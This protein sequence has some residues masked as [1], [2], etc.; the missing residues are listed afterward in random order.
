MLSG[1]L[2][3]PTDLCNKLWE[4][5]LQACGATSISRKKREPLLYFST[6]YRP[7][8]PYY[9]YRAGRLIHGADRSRVARLPSTY[10]FFKV[11][12]RREAFQ[13][14]ELALG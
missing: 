11:L 8:R 2:G 4:A 7:Y 10:F 3:T 9:W 12:D 13:V 1:S 5:Y 14:Y 6:E